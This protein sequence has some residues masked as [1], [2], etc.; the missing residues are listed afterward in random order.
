[1]PR[2]EMEGV[3][4]AVESCTILPVPEG[5]MRSGRSAT[6]PFLQPLSKRLPVPILYDHAG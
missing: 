2:S 4:T 3:T 5:G 6:K 1:M